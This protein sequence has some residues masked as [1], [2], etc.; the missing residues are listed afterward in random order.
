M[1]YADLFSKSDG[2]HGTLQCFYLLVHARNGERAMN[3]RTNNHHNM[4]SK[5]D[6]QRTNRS[7]S[8]T[9]RDDSVR[10][11]LSSWS[12]GFSRRRNNYIQRSNGS[13][14]SGESPDLPMNELII[15]CLAE[16]IQ[17]AESSSSLIETISTSSS[18]ST[19]DQDDVNDDDDYV[20]SNPRR[21]PN[22]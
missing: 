14:S 1:L 12:V 15:A 22:Q 17:I 9:L 21:N 13:S 4:S 18:A 16:V 2:I 11:L 20:E 19:V 8:T 3:N 6:P 10:T 5:D 7:T